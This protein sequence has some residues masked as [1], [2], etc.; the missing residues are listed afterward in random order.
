MKKLLLRLFFVP[1][2]AIFIFWLFTNFGKSLNDI[3]YN[4]TEDNYNFFLRFDTRAEVVFG[5]SVSWITAH[6]IF[7]IISHFSKNFRFKR[8]LTNLRYAPIAIILLSGF[9]IPIYDVGMIAYS[10]HQIRNYIFSNAQSIEK[11]DLNLHSNYR[12]WCGNGYFANQSY[13][14][15]E[16]ASEEINNKN[17]N[18]RARALFATNSIAD[19][20]NGTDRQRFSVVLSKG[21]QDSSEIVRAIAENILN[22]RNENCQNFTVFK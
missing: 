1:F 10:K 21:C 18:I 6:I 15:Y 9:I 17:P 2:N 22:D 7:E 8:L 3:I 13:L 14:Y 20:F 19:I 12:G 16:T 11:P 5:A 4:L